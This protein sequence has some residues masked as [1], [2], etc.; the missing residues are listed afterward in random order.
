MSK[1]KKIR[2]GHKVAY[3]SSFGTGNQ[4][5][6]IVTCIEETELP[7]QKYGFE[8]SSVDLHA[9]YVL[10]LDNGHWCFSDQVDHIVEEEN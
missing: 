10:T 9:N 4:E 8:V 2:I 1:S 6:A 3:R 7:R 5:T